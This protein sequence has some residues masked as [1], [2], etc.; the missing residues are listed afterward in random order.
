MVLYGTASYGVALCDM[1]LTC[2]STYRVIWC[3]MSGVW[4]GTGLIDD[5]ELGIVHVGVF[6]G[7]DV[8]PR[9]QPPLEGSQ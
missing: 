7:H 3:D 5:G 2:W 9:C 8:G 1:A 6:I 4:C